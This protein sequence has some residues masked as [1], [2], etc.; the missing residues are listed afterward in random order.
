MLIVSNYN[1][2]IRPV[3]NNTDKITVKM[4]LKLSQLVDLVIR[5]GGDGR[6]ERGRGKMR[7]GGKSEG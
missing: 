7:W 1:R 5:G 4:G 2:L 6:E 3:A